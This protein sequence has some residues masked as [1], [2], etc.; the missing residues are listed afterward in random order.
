MNNNG[1]HLNLKL[2]LISILNSASLPLTTSWKKR[3]PLQTSKTWISSKK[4]KLWNWTTF[5]RWREKQ[6]SLKSTKASLGWM[7][8]L[9]LKSNGKKKGWKG[10]YLHMRGTKLS[11]CLHCGNLDL[12][13]TTSSPNMRVWVRSSLVKNLSSQGHPNL[14]EIKLNVTCSSRN[15][16]IKEG[17]YSLSTK[18]S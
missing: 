1:N 16:V 4:S 13:T 18:Q 11:T 10:T 9:Q 15:G 3:C 7:L 6:S 12:K 8:R 14:S 5:R 17:N 2:T